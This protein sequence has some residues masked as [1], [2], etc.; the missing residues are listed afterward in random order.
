MMTRFEKLE[1]ARGDAMRCAMRSHAMPLADVDDVI[2]RDADDL[3]VVAGVFEFLV[4][5]H[6][7][8]KVVRR[9]RRNVNTTT[10]DPLQMPLPRVKRNAQRMIEMR[11]RDEHVRH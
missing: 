4:E 5:R 10:C 6:Q 11:M 1:R 3:D 9:F 2:R 7:R 8:A